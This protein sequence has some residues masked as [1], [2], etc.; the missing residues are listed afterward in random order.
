MTEQGT[1]PV[2]IGIDVSKDW[3]DVARSDAEAVMRFSNDD[4]GMAAL[5]D[6]LTARAPRLVV[7]EATGGYQT[8]AAATLDVAGLAVAVVNPRQVR[9]FARACGKRAKTDALDARLLA[10]F[11]QR[12]QPD[13][14]P[15][16]A[17]T[18]Q[19]LASLLRRRRQLQEMRTAERNRRPT[20][21]ASHL[22]AL[23]T[24]LAWL[25]AQIATVD[26]EL[27][28]T[29]RASPLWHAKATLLR[30]IPGIGPVVTATLLGCLPE[31][32]TLSRQ[33]AAA[34][35]GVAPMNQDSGTR[36]SSRHIWGGRAT[37]RTALYQAVVS[38]I[39]HNPVLRAL[40]QR[41]HGQ[42]GKPPKVAM[43]A[44]MRKLLTIA[45]AVVRDGVPWSPE[46]IQMA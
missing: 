12:V 46:A 23:E 22:P 3:L 16:A 4:K 29:L 39:R 2:W 25:T 8:L 31:L 21:P 27:A 32:G 28:D 26:A 1:T 37:V 24:H 7:R 40:Y 34:L 33:E 43:V 11:A 44:C 41:L 9:E 19:E 17:P 5:V 10:R 30:S 15:L 38:G 6:D 42:A 35:V 45:N 13:A 20:V 18:T 14:R 36:T